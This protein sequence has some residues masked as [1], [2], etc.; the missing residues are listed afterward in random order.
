MVPIVLFLWTQLGR[1]PTV[2]VGEQTSEP[3]RI[4]GW[5]QLPKQ[6]KRSG[7]DILL[8]QPAP[9]ATFSPYPQR[10]PPATTILANYQRST[11]CPRADQISLTL[12]GQAWHTVNLQDPPLSCRK[13][14]RK[15]VSTAHI[16]IISESGLFFFFGRRKCH[17]EGSLAKSLYQ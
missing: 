9:F 10:L 17:A 12:V 1:L 2:A 11:L 14:T 13:F 16:G 4:W 15:V 5:I 8:P 7:S 3:T 6:A